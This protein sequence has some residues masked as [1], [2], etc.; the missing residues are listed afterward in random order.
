MT[1]TF[2]DDPA[3]FQRC[4]SS[5]GGENAALQRVVMLLDDLS[6][7]AFIAR[8]HEDA[9]ILQDASSKVAAMQKA[10]SAELQAYIAEDQRRIAEVNMQRARHTRP[11]VTAGG[12]Q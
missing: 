10:S 11:T 12:A 8:R 3:E 5:K 7:K 2:S 6:A 9:R 4:W 1:P